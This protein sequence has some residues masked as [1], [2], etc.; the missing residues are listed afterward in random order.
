MGLVT[1]PEAF[2]V[3]ASRSPRVG[4]VVRDLRII[5]PSF[6]SRQRISLKEGSKPR[7]DAWKVLLSS[8]FKNLTKLDLV[9]G[10][11][12]MLA[13]PMKTVLPKAIKELK[14]LESFLWKADKI[15]A[16][17]VVRLSSRSLKRLAL[18]PLQSYVD[19]PL[20]TSNPDG[21]ARLEILRLSGI[22][23]L[24]SWR[25]MFMS[26]RKSFDLNSVTHAQLNFQLFR[27]ILFYTNASSLL[28]NLRCLHL[29]PATV[30]GAPV[31]RPSMK[32]LIQLE[33]VELVMPSASYKGL[34]TVLMWLTMALSHRMHVTMP[35]FVA[36]SHKIRVIILF[37][38]NLATGDSWE[39]EYGYQ[40]EHWASTYSVQMLAQLE[41]LNLEVSG[42]SRKSWLDK[43]W[44]IR[45]KQ[46]VWSEGDWDPVI[47]DYKSL[48]TACG[49]SGWE[50]AL[51][52]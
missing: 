34:P 11:R 33:L 48:S 25:S 20:A 18:L 31:D 23:D 47:D 3:L 50:G 4:A 14:S 10:A 19:P 29:G 40:V 30:N 28:T 17:M 22:L 13:E 16:D 7:L 49:C 41:A 42:F 15:S 6:H 35:S 39:D 44:S 38:S 51:E 8:D 21:V 5:L 24:D 27:N 37:Q 9:N 1:N 45:A 52:K 36:G 12:E 43:A 32:P 26:N 46:P 2:A